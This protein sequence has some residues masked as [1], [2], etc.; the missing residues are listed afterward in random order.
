MATEP[1]GR[2]ECCGMARR[3]SIADLATFITSKN[4]GPFLLTVDMVFPE[5]ETYRRV[6]ASGAI[7]AESVA[8][9]YGIPVEDV[10]KVV[11]FDPASAI[12]VTFKRPVSSGAIGDTDVYGAQQ[13]VPMMQYEIPWEGDE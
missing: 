4:A 12:K 1:S 13:H 5:A 3:V 7:T 6:V 2:K 9:L 8:E 11:Y 10:V